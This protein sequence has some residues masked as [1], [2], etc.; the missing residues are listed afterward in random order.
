MASQEDRQ[1][2]RDTHRLQ[3]APPDRQAERRSQGGASAP[4]RIYA[5]LPPRKSCPPCK[6]QQS[7]W[8]RRWVRQE[9]QTRGGDLARLCKEE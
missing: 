8:C 6:R 7:P 4:P 5:R 1:G 9:E 2:K 3:Q